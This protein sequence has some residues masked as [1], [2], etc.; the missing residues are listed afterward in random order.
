MG[1]GHQTVP[2]LVLSETASPSEVQ[3]P[4][5]TKTEISKMKL[6]DQTREYLKI[7]L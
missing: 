2:W 6:M 1:D 3:E 7:Q 5:L 4:Y